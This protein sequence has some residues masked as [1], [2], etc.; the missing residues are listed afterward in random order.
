MQGLKETDGKPA[1]HPMPLVLLRPLADVFVAGVGHY[2]LFNCLGEFE[3]PDALFWD[4][5]MRHAEQCQVD[6][7]A[8]DEQDGCYH[9]AKIAFNALMRLHHCRQQTVGTVSTSVQFGSREAVLPLNC[10]GNLCRSG[11]E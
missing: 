1:W 9:L 11:G 6:P 3:N 2:G 7:L 10:L 8:T 5:M 4:A